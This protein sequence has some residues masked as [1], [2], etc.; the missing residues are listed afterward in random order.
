[1]KLASYQNKDECFFSTG[2]A[3]KLFKSPQNM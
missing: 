1:M 3:D 2:Q